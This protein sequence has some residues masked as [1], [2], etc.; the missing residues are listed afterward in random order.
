MVQGMQLLSCAA[1]ILRTVLKVDLHFILHIIKVGLLNFE[2]LCSPT[3]SAR[4]E[5]MGLVS[6]YCP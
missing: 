4:I 6:Q 2:Q 1:G 3:I 5:K